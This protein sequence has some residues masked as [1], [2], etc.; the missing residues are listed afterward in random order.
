[1]SPA[2]NRT[3]VRDLFIF[4]LPELLRV[5]A[6]RAIVSGAEVRSH[7]LHGKQSR[8]RCSLPHGDQSL[9]LRRIVERCECC[10]VREFHH[11]EAMRS[12][13]ALETLDCTAPYEVAPAISGNASAIA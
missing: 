6:A 8:V 3:G 2:A 4:D 12:C 5:A 7:P 1:M 9:G 10:H 13:I 11:D